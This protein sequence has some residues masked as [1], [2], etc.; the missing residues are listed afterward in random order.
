[1]GTWETA[2]DVSKVQERSEQENTDLGELDFPDWERDEQH[3]GAK[4]ER[5]QDVNGLP[6]VLLPER[7]SK[8]SQKA[9]AK[10]ATTTIDT[11]SFMKTGNTL[12]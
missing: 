12:T 1:M 4:N 7:V 10:V 2:D 9:Q 6:F 5:N 11:A 3:E 8:D